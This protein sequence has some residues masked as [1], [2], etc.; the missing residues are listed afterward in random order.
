MAT[1][2]ASAASGPAISTPGR[3]RDTIAWTCAFSAPPVPTTA[4]FT[5]AGEYSPTSIPARA[6]HIS[7]T[8]RAWPSLSVDCGF[9][10]TNTSSAAAA[11]GRCSAMSASSWSASAARRLASG[12]A[13][14]VLSCP[15]ATWRRRLPSA[16]ITPQPVVPRPG[17][18]PRIFTSPHPQGGG[19]AKRRRRCVVNTGPLRHAAHDTSPEGGGAGSRPLLQLFLRHVVIAPDGLDVVVLFERIDEVHQLLRLLAADLDLGRRLPREL[20]AFRFAEH[21]LERACNLV[22]AVDR[23]PDTVAVLVAFDVLGAGLDR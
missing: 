15:L 8:P 18:R 5:S 4:F 11:S 17:S 19:G 21:G 9:L 2:S 7:T 12:A 22:Q 6:A 13:V 3:R 14:S 23:G 20:R 1:A 10:L 16:S